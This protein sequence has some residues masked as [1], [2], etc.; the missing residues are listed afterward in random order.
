MKNIQVSSAEYEMLLAVAKA[1]RKK[2][3]QVIS[4]Y[5]KSTYM[6]LKL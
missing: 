4:I 1:Q 6:G 2:P 3:N 5:I